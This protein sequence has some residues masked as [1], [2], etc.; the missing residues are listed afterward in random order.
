MLPRLSGIFLH[1]IATVSQFIHVLRL[2]QQHV[3][4]ETAERRKR[5]IDDVEKRRQ[6]RVAHGLEAESEAD[7]ASREK[8]ETEAGAAKESGEG[9]TTAE[10]EHVEVERKRK[11]L[12]KWLGIW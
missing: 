9:E 11:P 2:H 7:R 3:S 8:A 4:L 6:Y 12:K 1:P 10:G 5:N